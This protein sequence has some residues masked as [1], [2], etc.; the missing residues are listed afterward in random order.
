L[1]FVLPKQVFGGPLTRPTNSE[2]ARFIFSALQGALLAKRAT[3]GLDATARHHHG[4]ENA[5]DRRRLMAQWRRIRFV[6]VRLILDDSQPYRFFPNAIPVHGL[7][8]YPWSPLGDI[9]S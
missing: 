5:V 7:D 3:G 4:D 6:R 9:V 1:A 2:Q 8:S